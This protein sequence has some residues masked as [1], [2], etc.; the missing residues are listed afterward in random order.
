MP[1]NTELHESDEPTSPS[2]FHAR[3]LWLLVAGWIQP[4]EAMEI[5]NTADEAVAFSLLDE[6]L[7]FAGEDMSAAQR[8]VAHAYVLNLTSGTVAAAR[9]ESRTDAIVV[10]NDYAE[11]GISLQYE[12]LAWR[13][14]ERDVD[15]TLESR[16]HERD[17][18]NIFDWFNVKTRKGDTHHVE[19]DITAF[20]GRW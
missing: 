5:V 4:A 2:A 18:E 12:W 19:F 9:G 8:K 17:G 14:G 13:F 6:A 20:Y 11:E 16:G 15:W 1:V 10:V 7:R 3:Q